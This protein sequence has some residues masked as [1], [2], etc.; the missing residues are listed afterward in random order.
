MALLVTVMHG[1]D[2]LEI[3]DDHQPIQIAFT[4]DGDILEYSIINQD[5]LLKIMMERSDRTKQ[6]LKQVSQVDVE[7]TC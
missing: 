6:S 5:D 4:N 1:N 3:V 2:S 7:T